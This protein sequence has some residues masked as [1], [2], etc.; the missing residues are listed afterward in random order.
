MIRRFLAGAALGAF[1][2]WLA[3]KDVAFAEVAANLGRVSLAAFG[4]F[5]LMHLGSLWLRA[6]R[7][8]VLVRPL[9]PVPPAR[10]VPPL[11]IGFMVNFIL[12][13]RLGEIVRVWLLGRTGLVSASA[14][15]GSVVVER[16]T[17][18]FALLC[19][20]A[21]T[22]F[23]LGGEGS[24]LIARV[25]WLT[26]LLI[27]GY[28]GAVGALA[29]FGHHRGA[30]EGFLTR[31]PAVRRRPILMRAVG[32]VGKF[33][34]GLAVLKSGRQVAIAALL[35]LAL[36]G[37]AGLANL[38]M[39]R[40]FGLDLPPFAPFLLL[41]LQAAGF[42][43][44]V[45]GALGPF[46]YASVVALGVYGVAKGEALAFALITHTGLFVAVLAPGL[47]FAAREHLGLKEIR[48]A[49]GEARPEA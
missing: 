40:A 48:S 2:L 32:L 28:L 5:V 37:W 22:P 17:D 43:V 20:V 14:A 42:L 8:A 7:W 27:A 24:E 11:A 9:A 46:Q 41:I 6:V 35:S 13:A 47:L 15:F 44:P 23:F 36:W 45:P 16:L 4:L 26:P 19:M 29:L 1:F 12:P 10:L 31:H 25:R 34:E 39:L 21:I 33:A 38:V 18:V 3:L 30:I 49:A